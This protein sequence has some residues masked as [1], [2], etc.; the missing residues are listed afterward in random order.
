MMKVAVTASGPD[1]TSDVDPRFG[2]CAQFV[3]VNT[4]DMSFDTIENECALQGGGAGT[5]AGQLM[6]R[7][8][9]AAV[10]TGNC[11]PNAHRTLSAA[12]IDI[13]VGCSGTVEEAVRLYKS[14]QL[15]V[16][17]VP[18]VSSHA[19]MGSGRS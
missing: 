16:A 10:L 1:L 11:G 14:R 18:N 6:A 4:D 8:G 17:D 19:G 2:R 15:K 7:H 12:G 3:I 9:V 5:Q 13:F